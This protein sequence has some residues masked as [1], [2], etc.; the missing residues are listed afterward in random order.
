MDRKKI[1]KF[2]SQIENI[3]NLTPSVKHLTI[4]VPKDFD[5]YP[6]QFVSLI[7]NKDGK[8]IRRPYSIASRP[9]KKSIDLCIKIVPNGLITTLIDS[10]KIGDEI[11][12]LGPMGTFIIKDSS[13]DLIFISTGTGIGPFKSMINYLLEN[14]FK[15]KITLLTGY[16]YGEDVLYESEFKELEKQ[17][18]NFFYHRI[19]SKS[20][21]EENGYVQKLVEKKLSLDSHYYICGLREMVNSVKELLENNKIPKENVFFERYD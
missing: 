21:K 8:E 12:V 5:F 4:S 3:I 11:D 1:Y 14:N 13:K 17:S 9:S 10:L 19:L 20:E 6:G 18:K 16:R 15:N 2:K 7:L